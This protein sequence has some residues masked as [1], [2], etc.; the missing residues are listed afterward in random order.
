MRVVSR[1]CV[2]LLL[3]SL[4]QDTV[5]RRSLQTFL[6]EKGVQATSDEIANGTRVLCDV[7]RLLFLLQSY[8]AV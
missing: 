1:L 2:A 5:A 6:K 7:A 4:V 8:A 3:L